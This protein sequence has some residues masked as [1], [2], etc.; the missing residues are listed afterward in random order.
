VLDYIA[1]VAPSM[2]P[3]VAGRLLSVLRCPGGAEKQCF[4]QRYPAAAADASVLHHR[5]G[6]DEYFGINDRR[7]LVGL[8]QQN[9][10]EFHPWGARA[11]TL[12]QPDRL[13]L[14][15]AP[16]ELLLFAIEHGA[17]SELREVIA[18]LGLESLSLMHPRKPR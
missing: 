17:A 2:L 13:V 6:D 15:L 9:A 10:L 4:Y 7:G 3:H 18:A 8:A 16:D 14:D 12:E 11:T 1:R 5:D